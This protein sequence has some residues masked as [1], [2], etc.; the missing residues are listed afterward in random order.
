V[1]LS[2]KKVVTWAE[3]A[4]AD[5]SPNT[6][7][8]RALRYTDDP[9]GCRRGKIVIV[10]GASK[11]SDKSNWEEYGENESMMIDSSAHYIF[12]CLSLEL[13][14]GWLRIV[15]HPEEAEY[16]SSTPRVHPD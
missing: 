7:E 6:T 13:L 8:A 9:R 2:P 11:A 15:H 3:T 10:K 16:A 12:C 1:L 4:E 5:A 14:G